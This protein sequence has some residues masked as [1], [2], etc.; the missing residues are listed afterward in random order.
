RLELEG[1]LES[2]GAG[3]VRLR[4]ENG[5][6]KTLRVGPGAESY[7]GHGKGKAKAVIGQRV[8]V[9][10]EGDTVVRIRSAD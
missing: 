4:T 7:F 5:E 1:V 3:L 9:E 8:E 2:Y 6:V 10:V